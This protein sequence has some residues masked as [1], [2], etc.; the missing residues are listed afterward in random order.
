MTLDIKHKNIMFDYE[1]DA[2]AIV[3][4]KDEMTTWKWVSNRDDDEDG[5]TDLSQRNH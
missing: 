5:V 3:K 4:M 1:R 2:V